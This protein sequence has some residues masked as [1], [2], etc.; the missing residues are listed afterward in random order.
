MEELATRGANYEL[1]AQSYLLALLVRLERGLATGSVFTANEVP[2]LDSL[3]DTEKDPDSTGSLALQRAC[4]YIQAHLNESLSPAVVARHAYVSTPHLSRLF[5]LKQG[6]TIMKY[7]AHCRI[8]Q[9]RS[10]LHDTDLPVQEVGRLVGYHHLSHFSHAFSTEVG[11]A[12]LEFRKRKQAEPDES[13]F[14]RKPVPKIS[15]LTTGCIE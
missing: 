3:A 5:R 14:S 6:T 10:L 9:A 2:H 8:E 13:P 15:A 11:L 12:P 1:A 4:Q 7:V